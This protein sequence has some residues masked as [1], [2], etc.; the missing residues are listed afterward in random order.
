MNKIQVVL[1]DD[2]GGFD[3][4]EA[5]RNELNINDDMFWNDYHHGDINSRSDIKLIESFNRNEAVCKALG[6]SIYEIEF[7]GDISNLYIHDYDGVES[8]KYVGWPTR[9][10]IK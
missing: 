1:H 7:D 8:V 5:V 10:K 6:L 9:T 3:L 4:P 2:W